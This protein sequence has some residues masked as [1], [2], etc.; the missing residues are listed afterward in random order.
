MPGRAIPGMEIVTFS[1]DRIYRIIRIFLPSS[2][3]LGENPG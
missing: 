3:R 1:F 2:L